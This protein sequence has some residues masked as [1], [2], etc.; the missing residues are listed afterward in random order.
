MVPAMSL[1]AS[2]RALARA[3]WLA[4][5]ALGLVF[6]GAGVMKLA[7]PRAFAQVIAGYGLLPN[8]T[9]GLAAIILPVLEILAGAALAVNVRGGLPGVAGMLVLFMAVLGYGMRLG[10]DVDCGCFAPGDPEAEAYH[11]L[12]T[13]LA[14]DGVMLAACAFLH[15]CRRRLGIAHLSPGGLLSKLFTSNKET[16]S[17]VH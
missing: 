10:L 12:G 11:G 16:P 4:R 3:A 7:E 8:G 9:A 6:V 13:A 1:A 15:F 5:V 2:P 14:R 17:C